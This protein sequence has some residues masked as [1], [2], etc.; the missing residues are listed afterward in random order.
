MSTRLLVIGSL[1]C[2]MAG[3]SAA[4]TPGA[5]SYNAFGAAQNSC[6]SSDVIDSG[7]GGFRLRD[8]GGG[9]YQVQPNDGSSPFECTL[10]GSDLDCPNRANETTPI[11]GFDAE[12]V[13][14]VVADATVQDSETMQGTQHGDVSC[15]GSGCAAVAGAVGT[16]FPCSFSV[17]FDAALVA[18]E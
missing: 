12:L 1:V 10:S 11:G 8:L 5:W 7:G 9:A 2:T 4:P 13:V 6:N 3:C 16:T 18:A 17:D 15:Q 14:H